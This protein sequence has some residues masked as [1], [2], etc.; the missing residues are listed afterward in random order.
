[1]RVVL[2]I[3]CLVLAMSSL[4][5]AGEGTVGPNLDWNTGAKDTVNLEAFV[6]PYAS[7]T[8]GEPTKLVFTGKIGEIASAK[9]SYVV[10]T[11]CD[12]YADG[13]GTAFTHKKF[14]DVLATEYRCVDPKDFNYK[15]WVKAGEVNIDA[16]D[17]VFG[18][19]TYNVEY[20]ATL[21]GNHIS[22]QHAGD[23]SAT[24]T[25]VLWNP[26]NF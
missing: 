12:V 8:F 26:H 4:A 17:A 16:F 25:I 5:F 7:V 19:N 22:D 15:D 20:R 9:V 23:Y 14:G 2:L 11:N 21:G 18:V 13:K 1:M 10:D 24:Y 6:G 3:G